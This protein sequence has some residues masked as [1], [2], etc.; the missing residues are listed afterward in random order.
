MQ[1]GKFAK[2][3]P[4]GRA[5]FQNLAQPQFVGLGQGAVGERVEQRRELVVRIKCVACCWRERCGH[6]RASSAS[7]LVMQSSS[8]CR[9]RRSR[10]ESAFGVSRIAAAM[11]A[12]DAF[13][14]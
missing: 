3:L 5:P 13:G 4:R 12:T 9:I 6:G 7:V 10:S 11:S 1:R 8:T 14:S 2:C